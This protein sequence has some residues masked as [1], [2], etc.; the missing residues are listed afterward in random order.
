MKIAL[1]SYEYP[2]D[3]AYGGIATYVEQAARMLSE[4]GHYVEVFAGSERRAQS[5]DESG[6]LTHR[7]LEHDPA[8]FAAPAG[9][10][11]AE[12]HRT[13]HFDVLEGPEYFADARDAVARVPD[14]P[15]VVKLHTPSRVLLRLN[16]YQRSLLRKLR[17]VAWGLRHDHPTTWGYAP[18][19]EGHR[20]DVAR[21][22]AI[23]RAHA[24]DADEIATPSRSLG[25]TLEAEW[26][27]DR[28][29]I[30]CVP[31]PYAPTPALLD[32]PI[33]SDTRIVT[34]I[35]RLEARKGVLDLAA[36]VPHV[37]REHPDAVFRFVGATDDALVPGQTMRE[38]LEQR[39]RHYRSAI[40]FTGPLAP[41]AIPQ[42]LATTAVCVLPS[43]WENFPC[44]C[45]EAMAAGRAIV[46]SASGG[47]RE[48]LADGHAGH[49]IPPNSPRRLARSI[50]SLLADDGRRRELGTAARGR[51]LAEYAP[52]RIVSLQIASYTRAVERRR[53]LGPRIR[54]A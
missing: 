15:L 3:T 37:L 32:I 34:F 50:K 16:Y 52:D 21:R 5:S 46:A 12:R 48:M 30:A 11:F 45:L 8:R 41:A 22:D 24:R 35:G 26:G 38:H 33:G 42:A 1:I 23:E 40:E 27:L 17:F 29:R 36:A 9:D 7:I 28:A 2:P 39:L 10:A 43:L 44:V 6:I 4:R 18:E 25:D 20:V 14:I 51:L 53:A 54:S 19:I 31:Y 49:L 13:V 47:M